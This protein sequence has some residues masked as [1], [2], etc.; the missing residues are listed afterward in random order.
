M[1]G[2]SIWVVLDTLIGQAADPDHESGGPCLIAKDLSNSQ[3]S[4]FWKRRH[5]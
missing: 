4:L 5:I 3:R 1:Q 2:K